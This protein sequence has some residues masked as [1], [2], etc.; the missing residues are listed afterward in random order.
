MSALIGRLRHLRPLFVSST[1]SIVHRV[2]PPSPILRPVVLS[3]HA[4]QTLGTRALSADTIH[5]SHG[6]KA[7]TLILTHS[8]TAC[9]VIIRT[10]MM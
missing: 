5:P 6:S 7:Q 2:G 10:L 9:D 4:S 1:S 3:P 8:L